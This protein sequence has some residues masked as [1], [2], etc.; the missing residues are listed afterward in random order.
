[1]Y[2]Y[3]GSLL[4]S[5]I[6]EKMCE[7][8]MSLES[9]L[10]ANLREYRENER[11]PIV[12]KNRSFWW[13]N[14]WNSPSYWKFFLKKGIT[15]D[16]VLFS[17]SYRNDRNITELF[18]SVTLTYHAPCWDTRCISQNSDQMERTVPFDSTTEQLFCP[19]ALF[20]LAENCHWFFQINGKR[21]ISRLFSGFEPQI[22]Q[23][24]PQD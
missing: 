20:H 6:K 17:R 11:F 24:E 19:Y 10:K 21:S 1:M 2:S 12:R 22:I 18:A 7:G 5:R 16:V 3:V 15:S 8:L 9:Y 14:K 13:D 4:H 23:H